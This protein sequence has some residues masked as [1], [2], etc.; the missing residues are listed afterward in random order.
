[1]LGLAEAAHS[2]R[3]LVWGLDLPLMF[4]N[5]REEWFDKKT[6]SNKRNVKVK[7]H[8]FDC[9]GQPHVD[10]SGLYNCFF[11]PLSTCSIIDV[12]LL[13]MQDLGKVGYDDKKR[14][15]LQVRRKELVW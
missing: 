2:N 5:T 8:S 11:L 12:N 7:G 4:E 1:M 13:E 15:R 10:G 9:G 3:T 6:Y 14:V